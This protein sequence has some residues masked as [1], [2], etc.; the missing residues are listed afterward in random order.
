MK[1]KWLTYILVSAMIIGCVDYSSRKDSGVSAMSGDFFIGKAPTTGVHQSALIAEQFPNIK[2]G[3]AFSLDLRKNNDSFI[4][5]N[6]RR[7]ESITLSY[8]AD[9]NL[10]DFK[11]S[12][13]IE[14]ISEDLKKA[15]NEQLGLTSTN[16]EITKVWINN[17][18]ISRNKDSFN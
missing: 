16:N 6:I 4:D 9:K 2:A 1:G 18:S 7:L 12:A 15:F 10:S 13:A 17:I 3:I 5:N 14:K 8:L 11:G